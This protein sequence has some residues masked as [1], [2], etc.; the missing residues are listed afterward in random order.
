MFVDMDFI[1]SSEDDVYMRRSLK[2]ETSNLDLADTA[3]I[4]RSLSYVFS[5]TSSTLSP[6]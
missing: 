3:S 6:Y 4:F 2:K 1:C 5:V